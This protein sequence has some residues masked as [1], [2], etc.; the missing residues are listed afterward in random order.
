VYA[1]GGREGGGVAIRAGGSGDVTTS[2]VVWTGN[3]QARI[4]SPIYHDGAIYWIANGIANCIDAATGEKIYQ[5]RLHAQEAVAERRSSPFQFVVQETPAADNQPAAPQ[6]QATDNPSGGQGPGPDS[7][8]RRGRGRGRGRG[9][10]GFGGGFM[11]QDYSSP[12]VADGKIY[13][14]RRNG[15]VFVFTLGR[16][17]QQLAINKFPGEA[18]YS[19]TPA[20]A[21][22]NIYI[23]SSKKLYCVANE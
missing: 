12:V 11:S 7:G 14:A 15:E 3:Q 6:A 10:R 16:E 21:D 13:F 2:H 17:F 23:R 9:G 18:D 20:I 4:G 22:G 5:E 8:E 19:S 1:I